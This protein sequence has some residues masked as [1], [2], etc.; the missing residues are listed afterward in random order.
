MTTRTV[1]VW[2]PDWPVRATGLAGPVAVVEANRVV[3]ASAAARAEGVRVGQRRRQAEA[4]CPGLVVVGRDRD[5]EARAFEPVVSAISAFCPMVEVLRPG[6]CAFAARGPAR[7]FGGE[8]SLVRQLSEVM[9]E[10]GVGVADGP[11]AAELAARRSLVVSPGETPEFLAPFPIRVL[12][13]P[14]L[15][16]LLVRLG[17]RTL[18][19][20]AALPAPQVLARFGWEGAAAQRLARGL[21]ER[22]LDT[23]RPPEDLSVAEELDPPVDRVDVAAF[24]ARSLAD[25]L[26]QGLDRG[27]WRCRVVRIEAESEHGE[28]LSRTWRLGATFSAAALVERVRWQLDGWLSSP[29]RPTAGLTSIRL[30]PD[31]VV[32]DQGSQLGFWGGVAEADRRAARALDRVQGLLGPDGALLAVLEGGRSPLERARL[33]PWGDDRSALRRPEEP[34]PGRVP[35]PPP[36]RL[37]A[38][39]GGGSFPEGGR[40]DGLP[41]QAEVLDRTGEAVVVRKRGQ[42]RG[43]PDRLVLGRSSLAVTHWSAPWPCEERWWDPAAARRRAWMQVVVE[44]GRAFLLSTEAGRWSLEAVYD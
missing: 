22:L 16:D 44:D 25:R 40:R 37:A 15:T 28:K 17:I 6:L 14:E 10:C 18:G 43:S 24:V 27:G 38:P 39:V 21:D 42:L 11:F 5:R 29:E 26:H 2:C 41:V 35:P 1:M 23:R 9:G 7:F 31:G 12:R 19:Q 34:W 32:G 4:A 3:V 13:R 20:L 36:S 30:V 33:V 8:A